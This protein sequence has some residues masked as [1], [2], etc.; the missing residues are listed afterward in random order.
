MKTV[1]GLFEQKDEAMRAFASLVDAGYARADLDI[2]TND[3]KDDVPKLTRMHSWVPE[4]DVNIYLAGVRDGGTIVTANVGNSTV[5]RAASILGSYNMV[6]IGKRAPS[7]AMKAA[8]LATATATLGAAAASVGAAAK[9]VTTKATQ[10]PPKQTPAAAVA[11]PTA[12]ALTDPVKNDNVLEVIEEDL[13]VGKEQVERGRMRIY[14]V[15]TEREVEKNVALKDETLRVQ[16]RPVNRTVSIDPDLFKARSFEMIEMDEIA[17]V[18]KTARVVEE[19]TIGKEV[20]DKIET[21]KETLRRQDVQ[22]EEIPAVRPF[23]SYRDDFRGFYT[24]HLGSSGV[25]F[26][27][28]L[29]TFRFGHNLATKEPFRS[30]PWSAVEADARRIWEAKNP[31]TWDQSKGVVHYAWESVRSAR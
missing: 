21:I 26:D 17:K 9:T 19:V 4:P 20:V 16:R 14:N 6:N 23:D 11:P 2:L 12:G 8:P 13:S 18:K 3:D 1:I 31:G 10:L 24:K 28:L 22:M 7:L 25:S 30:S 15:V 5:A 29:P 27:S